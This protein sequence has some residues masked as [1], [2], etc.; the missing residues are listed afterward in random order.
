MNDLFTPAGTGN[1]QSE[2][3]IFNF[4]DA[5]VRTV[6]DES[7]NP[8]FVAKDVCDVLE[9]RTDTVRLIVDDDE[10]RETNPKTIGIQSGGR[11]PLI[12][13]ES[14]LYSLVLRSRK[15]EAKRFRKWVTSEVLPS[16]RATGGYIGAAPDDDEAS[17]MARALEIAHATLERNKA[18]LEEANREIKQLAPDA[19][20]ARDV[21]ASSNLHTVNSI[22]VH[23]GISAIKLNRFLVDRGFIY[24]QGDIYC[25]SCKIRDKG[26]CD[27]HVVPY[28]NS[29]GDKMTREHLKWTEAGRKFVIEEYNKNSKNIGA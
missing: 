13:S 12:V 26:Y 9:I 28:I 6:K 2:L 21:L 5:P 15:P 25:P 17:I 11:N 19:E 27:F 24:K 29:N 16:I 7:G 18:R 1:I 23:L 22:A 10:V 4:N 8:W 14:G 20:Y 3:R